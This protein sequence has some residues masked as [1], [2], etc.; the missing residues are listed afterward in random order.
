[1]NII[2]LL[3]IIVPSSNETIVI[4]YQ[5]VSSGSGSNGID[6]SNLNPVVVTIIDQNSKATDADYMA[7]QNFIT[8]STAN[9]FNAL[10]DYIEDVYIQIYKS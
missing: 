6:T 7:A 1:M 3:I 2:L 4:T 5:N 8:H 10:I 9:N